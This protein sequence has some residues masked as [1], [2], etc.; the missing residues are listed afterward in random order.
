MLSYSLIAEERVRRREFVTFG[1][2]ALILSQPAFAQQGAR[3][4]RIGVLE[5][6]SLALNTENFCAFRRGLAEL[7]YIEGQNLVIEYRSADGHQG[8]FADLAGEL[9]RLNVDLIVTR[10]T[11]AAQAAKAATAAVPVVMAGSGDPV[12]TGIVSSLARPGGNITGLSALNIET[13]GKRV[14]ILRELVPQLERIAGLFN[15][16]NPVLQPQWAETQRAAQSLGLES[17]LL[18]VREAADLEGAF[19]TAKKERVGALVVA[20]DSLTQANQIRIVQLAATHRL[21][22]IY[23]A[24]EFVSSGGLL[25][26]TTDFPDLYYRAARYV[27]KILKGGKP[28]DLPIEQSTKFVMMINLKTAKALGLAIPP[29]LLARADEVIE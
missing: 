22:T 29:A 10:G 15:M 17:R 14:E 27:D 1:G 20:L 3:V 11:P 9:V 23:A 19:Q 21:P 28:A 18:D 13:Y 8:R 26:Y 12:G 5:T 2:A 16:N 25:A 24:G 4:H 6:I 7:G